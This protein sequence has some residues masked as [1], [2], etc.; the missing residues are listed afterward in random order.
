MEPVYLR[1]N[2]LNA[3]VATWFAHT[4]GL[5]SQYRFSFIFSVGER[6]ERRRKPNRRRGSSNESHRST[7]K[8][9]DMDMLRRISCQI[10]SGLAS[11]EHHIPRTA[12]ELHLRLRTT[13][14]LR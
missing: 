7:R 6:K 10:P 12:D 14:R 5:V 9:A 2:L 1:N 8:M 3:E 11:D 4:R 13:R